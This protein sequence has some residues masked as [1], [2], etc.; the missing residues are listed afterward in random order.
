MRHKAIPKQP[1]MY[2]QLLPTARSYA[3][4]VPTDDLVQLVERKSVAS[5]AV[6][7]GVVGGEFLTVGKD[8]L[9]VECQH[10]QHH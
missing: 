10:E 9:T 5:I 1:I 6:P 8:Q 2:C 4:T 7:D 3:W